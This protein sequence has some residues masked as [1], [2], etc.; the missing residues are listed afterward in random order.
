MK[1]TEYFYDY[2]KFNN[3]KE[4]MNSSIEKYSENVAFIL[5]EKTEKEVSYKNIT[6]SEFGEQVKA[7]GTGLFELG[8]QG[9]R[10]AIIG[11]NR[12]EWALSYV[13]ILM[14][15][16]TAVPL[17]KGLTDTEIRNS[18]MQSKADAII[19]EEKYFEIINQ[20]KEEEDIP[21]KQLICMDK[22][23]GVKSVEEV[24]AL[25]KKR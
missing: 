25:G 23:D 17:D 11:K 16:M 20:L 21:L 19:F 9:K 4:L 3:I 2:P 13:A 10:I 7:F 24:L 8:L 14:G 18:L 1:N 5:K 12:Y 6:Y 22:M 15:D